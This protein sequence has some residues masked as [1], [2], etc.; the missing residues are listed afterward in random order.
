MNTQPIDEQTFVPEV[1]AASLQAVQLP[2]DSPA[3]APVQTPNVEL[4]DDPKEAMKALPP[5]LAQHISQLIAQADT[6]GY[7]RGRNEVI[8]ATQHFDTANDDSDIAPAPIPRYVHR[9]IWD[10]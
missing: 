7:L 2:H 5:A 1:D 6:D 8:E 4:P 3:P 10:L 9:S